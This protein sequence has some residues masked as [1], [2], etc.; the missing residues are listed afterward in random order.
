MDKKQHIIE[1]AIE[2]F[3]QKGFEGT[4][5]RDLAEKADVNVAMINYY[6]GSKEKLFEQLVEYKAAYTRGLLDE[7]TKNKSLSDIEKIDLIIENYVNRIFSNRNYHRVITQ[8]L[9]LQKESTQQIIVDLLFPNSVL[10]KSVIDS[11]IRKGSFKKIDSGLTIATIIG[12]IN[13]ILL[14]KKM[15][16]K[17]L[18]KDES[19]IPYDDV[20]FK[21]KVTDH[22]K[23]LMHSH[24][25]IQ[26]KR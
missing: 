15:C 16:N 13:Q 22:L 17:M 23:Q 1:T 5:I 6:F 3:A 11:G 25:L 10:I 26:S 19:F 20:K 24:L 8:E 9:M 7:I 4:S 14:S 12:T 21:N 2:L 18:N